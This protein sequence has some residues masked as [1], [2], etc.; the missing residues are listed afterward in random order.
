MSTVPSPGFPGS[1]GPPRP[2][3]W[4]LLVGARRSG[5]AYGGFRITYKWGFESIAGRGLHWLASQSVFFWRGPRLPS[6]RS[7][8]VPGVL[9]RRMCESA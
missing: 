8:A 4:G 7:V 6:G 9:D 3:A 1:R 5:V 2:G